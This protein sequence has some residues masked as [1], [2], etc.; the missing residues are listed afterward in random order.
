MTTPNDDKELQDEFDGLCKILEDQ[1]LTIAEYLKQEATK[2]LEE[3]N[4]TDK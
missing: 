2:I 4:D 1:G 3:K